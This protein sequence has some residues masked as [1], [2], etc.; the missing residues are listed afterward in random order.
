MSLLYRLCSGNSPQCTEG[1]L[2]YSSMHNT[3]YKLT[4]QLHGIISQ[5]LLQNIIMATLL[6]ALFW[7]LAKLF[8]RKVLVWLLH[9]SRKSETEWDDRII[10]ALGLPFYALIILIGL[11]FALGTIF[12]NT[13]Y[14]ISLLKFFRTGLIT[15][16][17]WALYR[18]STTT[19]SILS[20]DAKSKDRRKVDSVLAALLSKAAHFLI[21]ALVIIIIAGEW[22]FDV[23]GFIAGLGLGGLALA[24]AAKDMLANLF[25]GVVI[26]LE[27]S[28]IIG[29]WISIPEVEGT[30]ESISFRSTGIRTFEQSLVTVPNSVLAT[31]A[32]TNYSRMGKRKISFSLGLPYQTSKKQIETIVHKIRQ[33]LR[34][35]P[36]IHP[37]TILVNF[38]SFGESGLNIFL[39]FF[40]KTTIW[41]DYLLVKEEINLNIIEI[42][43]EEGVEVHLPSRKL[44]LQS[45]GDVK[46]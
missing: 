41:A 34:G 7:L 30:V 40:T 24:L 29:D 5:P 28:F 4:E 16:F 12:N 26:L 8:Y 42:L 33:M 31:Q 14:E 19:M 1:W 36:A 27:K 25:G 11:Y 3:I 15:I 21:I 46:I 22:G 37:E 38:D 44:Y 20:Q 39:Y 13:T 35:H 17:G 43:E 10:I 32:V 23:N 2:I 6:F 45:C 9:I 18:L